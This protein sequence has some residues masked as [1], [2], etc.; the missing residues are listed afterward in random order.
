MCISFPSCDRRA[1]T[2]MGHLRQIDHISL[3]TFTYLWALSPHH[4]Y[5]S[6]GLFPSSNNRCIMNSHI[7]AQS[8][9][10]ITHSSTMVLE[11]AVLVAVR[12]SFPCH[13]FWCWLYVRA[14]PSCIG[15]EQRCARSM[16]QSIMSSWLLA[17]SMWVKW[18]RK[19]WVFTTKELPSQLSHAKWGTHDTK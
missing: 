14:L 13:W 16:C 8:I 1:E 6:L 4:R 9:P 10:N 17:H 11:V 3:R 15:S 2:C 7:S 19:A 12:C 18:L 5:S